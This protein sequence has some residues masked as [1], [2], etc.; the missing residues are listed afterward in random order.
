MDV[1]ERMEYLSCPEF[2]FYLGQVWIVELPHDYVG[3]LVYGGVHADYI[4]DPSD[5]Q[6]EPYAPYT[7]ADT[8]SHL[9]PAFLS[10]SVI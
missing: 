1:R 7:F 2:L 6:G 5:H 10:S 9:A 8:E 4:G 3:V